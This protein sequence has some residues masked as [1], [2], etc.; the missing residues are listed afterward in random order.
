MNN[1]NTLVFRIVDLVNFA[2][3]IV[4]ADVA[5]IRAVG[6]YAAQDVHKG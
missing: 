3:F 4:K 6:I 2:C 1:Y 5:L